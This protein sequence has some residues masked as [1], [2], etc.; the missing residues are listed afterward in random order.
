METTNELFFKL[1]RFALGTE[2]TIPTMHLRE[3]RAMFQ[4]AKK[5]ALT[6]F[7]G[8]S[9]NSISGNVL[10]ETDKK[11]KDAFEDLIMKWTGDVVKIAR[12][13]HKVNKDVVEEFRKLETKGLEC[14]L[15]KGQGNALMYPIPDSRTSG[16][17]DVWV[18]FKDSINTDDN[19]RKIIK[20]VRGKSFD[21][22]GTYHHIDAPN[23]NGTPVEV[24]YRPQFLFFYPHDKELQQ[25]FIE[26]ADEQ[27]VHKVNFD[28]NEI[29]VPTAAFNAVCQLSH[30]YNHLFNEGIGLR[31]I[32][33]YYYVLQNLFIV[34]TNRSFSSYKSSKVKGNQEWRESKLSSLASSIQKNTNMSLMLRKMGLYHI[35][36][37]IMWILATQLGMPKEWMIVAPDEKRGRF[38]LSEIL[39]SGNFGKF[40]KRN[41]RFGH[42][43]IGRNIQRI[44]R[45]LRLVRYFP[46]EALSEPFFRLWHAWWRFRHN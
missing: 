1:L 15:L 26:N 11:S 10:I 18:R 27:F 31:Q 41:R 21:S 4:M 33:D 2:S 32:V 14:C 13:N 20:L 36:G 43:R 22:I 28:E 5:Q 35:S 3:W 45:D 19:I 7:I 8:S 25:F 29:A 37:A 12:R 39:Q 46:S 16:D 30:I 40:D 17:I 42:S 6:G 44:V 38:V 23:I 9:L 34:S 24:H